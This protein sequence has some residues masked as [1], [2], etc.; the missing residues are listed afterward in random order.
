MKKAITIALV[1]VL[2]FSMLFLLISYLKRPKLEITETDEYTCYTNKSYGLNKRHYLDICVPKGVS[3]DVGVMLYI[4]GGGWIAGDKDGYLPTLKENAK[5]GYITVALNYR[6]AN[7][8]GVTCED[9]LDDIESALETVKDIAGEHGLNA[10]KVM[11]LG[12]SAGAHLS[13]MYAYTRKDS[14]PIEP[15][16]AVSYA[17]PT[18]LADP[19][20]FITQHVD[21]IEE[22]I[23]KISGVKL[24][25]RSVDDCREELLSASPIDY[26]N[27]E[28]VP[29][30][31]FHGTVDDVVPY[32]N[33]VALH[34]LL[35]S[36]GVENEFVTFNNSGHGLE[37]DPEASKRAEELVLE[38]AE[39][40]LK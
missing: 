32:S 35:D 19:N 28:T 21:S 24:S 9:I 11:L 16:A 14:S 12:G 23:S 7:G 40:Y 26:V 10:N 13:L 17:G 30:L 20:F 22:M 37:S 15:L 33:A 5:R 2:V 3:G 29:T 31:I 18:D 1:A 36:L 6:Y 38:Y 4:H 39:R 27:S 34:N 8:R 25:R